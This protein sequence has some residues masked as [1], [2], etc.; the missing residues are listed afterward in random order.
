VS[1]ATLEDKHTHIFLKYS[2]VNK[3]QDDHL[4][5]A[6]PRVRKEKK[7]GFIIAVL[8]VVI[9]VIVIMRLV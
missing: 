6:L 1:R 2:P 7:M 9:L 3:Q 8:V 4:A 5:N